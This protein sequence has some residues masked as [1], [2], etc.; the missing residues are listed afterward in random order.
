[1]DLNPADAAARPPLLLLRRG[2]RLFGAIASLA[3]LGM[4]L[5]TCVDVI[6]RYVLN[7]PITG[8]FELDE[9]SMGALVFAS[10]PLVS[11]RRQHV[12]VDLLDWVLP[13]RW[14]PAQDAEA[15]RAA[16]TGRRAGRFHWAP[17]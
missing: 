5:L 11:L 17:W 9:M 1:M 12:T 6:G 15:T 14:R 2:D 8:A 13:A 10:L 7:R 16:W 4:V 3:L